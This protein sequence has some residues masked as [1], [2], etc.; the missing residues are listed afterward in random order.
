[1]R[2]EEYTDNDEELFDEI[3]KMQA[4]NIDT[5]RQ[6]YNLSYNFIYKLIYDIVG[7]SEDN[8]QI[9][10]EIYLKIYNQLESL[11]HVDEFYPWAGKIATNCILDYLIT[12][13]KMKIEEKEPGDESLAVEEYASED[14]EKFIPESLL[15]DKQKLATV[16][17]FIN[18][19][20]EQEKVTVQYYYY[21]DMSVSDIADI[22]GCSEKTVKISIYHIKTML[23]KEIE[24]SDESA[25][26]RIYSLAEA[27]ILLMAFR[28][29]AVQLAIEMGTLAGAATGASGMTAGAMPTGAAALATGK[30]VAA[31][32]TGAGATAGAATA[33]SAGVV[34]VIAVVAVAGVA[35]VGA[36]GAV[37][38]NEKNQMKQEYAGVVSAYSEMGI[39]EK[40]VVDTIYKASDEDKAIYEALNEYCGEYNHIKQAYKYVL[41]EEEYQAA[42]DAMFT[43][44]DTAMATQAI[45][46]EDLIAFVNENQDSPEI[47]ELPQEYIG[48]IRQSSDLLKTSS[49]FLEDSLSKKIMTE[50]ASAD[51][52][53]NIFAMGGNVPTLI[54][55]YLSTTTDEQYTELV[56]KANALNSQSNDY[57][58]ALSNF[59]EKLNTPEMSKRWADHQANMSDETKA[60][61]QKM[62]DFLKQYTQKVQA[63]S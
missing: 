3:R 16:A 9:M 33:V 13:R 48:I 29:G 51:D 57:L 43:Q 15:E 42:E 53:S 50:E 38:A 7:D 17:E 19:L 20:S 55:T 63:T 39:D 44:L 58:T 27:P 11:Y 35:V 23:K 54:E 10:Q 14:T 56:N 60:Y 30:A 6:V 45:G 41:T 61:Y 21:E 28:A 8:E 22:M 36:H 18:R 12:N 31:G 46:V 52:V 26:M 32:A 37:V 1:M 34:K 47:Q 49:D 40:T 24:K 4:G 2:A 25:G 5:C 59:T 62:Q